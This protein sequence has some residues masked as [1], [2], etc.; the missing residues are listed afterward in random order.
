MW[1]FTCR[2][3]RP[4]DSNRECTTWLVDKQN[5]QFDALNV[6]KPEFTDGDNFLLSLLRT[7]FITDSSSLPYCNSPGIYTEN[8]LPVAIHF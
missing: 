1:R 5:L 7:T 8:Y 6:V 4:R 3:G 2:F